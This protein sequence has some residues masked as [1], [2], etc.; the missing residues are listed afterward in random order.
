MR[1]LSLLLNVFQLGTEIGITGVWV[2]SNSLCV[3]NGE[4]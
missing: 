4:C 3:V 1:C 2:S